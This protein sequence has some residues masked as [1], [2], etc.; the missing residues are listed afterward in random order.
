MLAECLAALNPQPGQIFVDCTVGLAGHSVELLRRIGPGGRLIALDLDGSYLGTAETRL[1]SVGHPFV[2]RRGN[3]AALQATL[4]ELGIDRVHGVLAD[5]GMSSMQVDDPSRG[6]SH[7]RDGPL[8]MRM[9]PQRGPTAADLLA[10][11]SEADLATAFRQCDEPQADAIAAAIARHRR[12]TPLLRTQELRAVV[13]EAAPVRVIRSPGAGSPRKQKLAPVTRVFQALRLLVNRELSN[14]QQLLRVLPI[15]LAP[16]G[17]AAIISFH[18]GEDRLVKAA[19]RDGRNQ[20]LYGAITDEP[21][22]PSEEEKRANPRARSAKL[23]HARRAT[24]PNADT[25]S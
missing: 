10:E 6:F 25:P 18:S 11:L 22:R 5:L 1:K 9:D 12:S 3:F 24:S 17:V 16:N 14:L 20:G 4:L 13:E 21:V 19:F 23:R 2:I 7:R 8:D 15:V